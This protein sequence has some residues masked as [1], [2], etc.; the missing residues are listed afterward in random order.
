MMCVTRTLGVLEVLGISIIRNSVFEFSFHVDGPQRKA[1]V[2]QVGNQ[3]LAL[4]GGMEHM[5]IH[6][7]QEP[8]W[9]PSVWG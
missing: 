2:W 6:M 5:G 9:T 4:H 8:G 1:R 3:R 7:S